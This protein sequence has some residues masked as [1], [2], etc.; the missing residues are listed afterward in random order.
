MPED[1]A[2]EPSR[3]ANEGK[4]IPSREA[5]NREMQSVPAERL[6]K[7]RAMISTPSTHL[8][9]LEKPKK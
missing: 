2:M 9:G 6:A 5:F 8:V 4:Q 1:S 3:P 7:I